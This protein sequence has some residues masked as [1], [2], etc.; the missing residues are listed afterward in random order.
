MSLRKRAGQ[1]SGAW[2]MSKCLLLWPTALV[3]LGLRGFLGHGTDLLNLEGSWV[4]WD[5][6]VSLLGE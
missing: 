5:E 4:N 1:S 2:L 6:L 3:C